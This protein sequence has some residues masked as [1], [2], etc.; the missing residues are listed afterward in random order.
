MQIYVYPFGVAEHV[1]TQ[2]LNRELIEKL[3][4]V[5]F[6]SFLRFN[7]P[8]IYEIETVEKIQ[9]LDLEIRVAVLRGGNKH[10]YGSSWKEYHRI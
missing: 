9:K 5:G 4:S 3:N 1:V 8:E 10:K 6:S 2:S 7:I